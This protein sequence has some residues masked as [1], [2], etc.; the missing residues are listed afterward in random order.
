[1]TASMPPLKLPGLADAMK[2][3]IPAAGGAEE[4]GKALA[5]VIAGHKPM[6]EAFVAERI[7]WNLNEEYKKVRPTGRRRVDKALG[8]RNC[9]AIAGEVLKD[10]GYFQKLAG[11]V[12]VNVCYWLLEGDP[13]SAIDDE[14]LAALGGVFV[15]S[16]VQV[17]AKAMF[18]PQV[19]IEQTEELLGISRGEALAAEVPE[20]MLPTLV[21]DH[22]QALR[23][24]LYKN[25]FRHSDGSPWPTAVFRG[26]DF[27]AQLKPPAVD[28]L[29][30]FP[31]DNLRHLADSMWRQQRELSDRDADVLDG[32]CAIYLTQARTPA[33]AAVVTID[34]LL[35]MRGLKRKRGGGGRRGGYEVEQRE[36]LMRSLSHIQNL[37]LDIVEFVADGGAPDSNRRLQSRPFVITDRMG[38][39]GLDGSFEMEKFV[40]RP[41]KALATLIFGVGRQLGVLHHRALSYDPYRRRWEKRLTRYLSWWWPMVAETRDNASVFSVQML[42]DAVGEAVDERYPGRTRKRLEDALQRLQDDQVI[43]A[44]TYS[45]MVPA[46]GAGRDWVQCWLSASV[47]IEATMSVRDY[48]RPPYGEGDAALG[49]RL[50]RRRRDSGLSQILTADI[51]GIR[52]GHLSKIEN[53]KLEPSTDLRRRI[54]AWLEK[55]G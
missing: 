2:R 12:A 5:P 43:S 39:Q 25:S 52:Q 1:M 6:I 51:F 32:L 48:Y 41:G 28:N 35:A 26:G 30:W 36:D 15:E 42:L 20:G 37:W 46:I 27:V 49:R 31:E 8:K 53:G 3:L 24:A 4:V 34:Q 40:F 17:L 21:G 10:P 33:D 11:W 54:E 44:W 19:P 14:S 55:M 18:P 38:K 47:A 13:L 7:G 9:R 29:P 16:S 23:E 22:F 50:Y 45:G